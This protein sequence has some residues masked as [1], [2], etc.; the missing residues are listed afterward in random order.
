MSDVAELDADELQLHNGDS[1][2][3][4]LVNAARLDGNFTT[5]RGRLNQLINALDAITRDDNT[6]NDSLVRSRNLHPEIFE[7]FGVGGNTVNIYQTVV[8]GGGGGGDG[9]SGM[10]GWI[11]VTQSPYNALGD[12]ASHSLSADEAAAYNAQFSAV[13]AQGANEFVAGMQRDFVA[14][15]AALWTAANSGARVWIPPGLYQMG[16]RTLRLSWTATPIA[17]QP[18][19]PILGGIFGAGHDATQLA[20]DGLGD[21]AVALELLGESNPYAVRTHIQCFRIYH[22]AT[23]HQRAICLRV[24]DC[25]ELFSAYRVFC[26]G[27]NGMLVKIASSATYAQMCTNFVECKFDANYGY[28]WGDNTAGE[29]YS[30]F[31]DSGGAFWDNVKF[32]SCEFGGLVYTRASIVS[33][34]NCQFY[35][36]ARRAT[37]YDS[38]IYAP[39]GRVNARDCYFEDYRVAILLTN[40][41][42]DNR[43]CTIVGNHFS[44]TTN[45]VGAPLCKHAIQ[46]I[47]FGVNKL[48][49][50]TITDNFM[51][52]APYSL[53]V[54]GH[55]QGEPGF[56]G[57]DI[58]MPG[59]R[60]FLVNNMNI[61]DPYV[62]VTL[63]VT[64]CYIFSFDPSDDATRGLGRTTMFKATVEDTLV[65]GAVSVPRK[66]GGTPVGEVWGFS[67]ENSGNTDSLV[68][69]WSSNTYQPTGAI[70]WLGNDMAFTYIPAGKTYRL[71]VGIS[72][73]TYMEISAAGVTFQGWDVVSDNFKVG[74]GSP[75]GAVTGKRGD[76]LRNITCSYGTGLYTKEIGDGNNTGWHALG[77][78]R[79]LC[80]GRG[81]AQHT[82]SVTETSILATPTGVRGAL[83][84]PAN[85]IR[86]TDQLRVRVRGRIKADA[87]ETLRLRIKLGA[88]TEIDTGA[89]QVSPGGNIDSWF[90]AEFTTVPQ[91]AGLSY[92]RMFSMRYIEAAA[93]VAQVGA[94]RTW[95]AAVVGNSSDLTTALALDITAEFGSASANNL[96]VVHDLTVERVTL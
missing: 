30:V 35:S 3:R 86:D 76:I 89:I 7:R 94:D 79:T 81:F 87:T 27:A 56:E 96:I 65:A 45:D 23:C 13:G 15:Q 55:H 95:R 47:G 66:S 36:N 37:I 54:N 6:L 51:N 44:G 50:F 90:E 17:G 12:G 53:G 61:Y 8:G 9:V 25:K 75:E 71:G 32:D 46:V 43:G 10:N 16:S 19:R 63:D 93:A 49:M 5:C 18:Q 22:Y 20:W 38:C 84:I 40:G 72:S 80:V 58:R 77:A 88:T 31:P 85:A 52:Y 26:E 92:S 33:F 73:L 74:V 70:E 83:T 64:G 24:G 91:V 28:Q 29:F 57:V 39:I 14:I 78:Q 68:Q 67:V 41:I 48:G 60:C 82:A 62:A 11:D 42:Y 2:A 21:G 1:S 69:G 4:D 34:F 59:T